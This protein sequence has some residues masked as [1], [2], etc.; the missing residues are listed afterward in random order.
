[1]AHITIDDPELYTEKT[2]DGSGRIYLG[3]EWAGDRVKIV[4]ESV[5]D[6]GEP[7]AD[8]ADAND[9]E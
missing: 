1:M 3:K 7:P 8:A 6:S 9:S 5:V 4:I 2:V